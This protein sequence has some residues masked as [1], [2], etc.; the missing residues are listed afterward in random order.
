VSRSA[1]EAEAPGGRRRPWFIADTAGWHPEL[2]ERWFTWN[3]MQAALRRR[4]Q[5]AVLGAVDGLAQASD[6]V[7]EVGCGTGAHTIGLARRCRRVVAVDASAEMLAYLERRLRREAISNVATRPGRLPDGLPADGGYD[8][9][10][11]VGVLN[12][13]PDLDA[14]LRALAETLRP[15]GWAVVTMPRN[16]PGGWLYRV[17]ETLTRR[18]VSL[19][20]EAAVCA[21]AVR[22]GLA[23]ARLTSAGFSRRGFLLVLAAR[24]AARGT[25]VE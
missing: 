9:V 11:A 7:L 4:E 10:L 18:R 23:P 1:V 6:R 19:R 20:S 15:G 25:S 14:A 3:P 22:A 13:L 12:Y 16:S 5:A 21:A 8:G 17:G 2:Y 24:R